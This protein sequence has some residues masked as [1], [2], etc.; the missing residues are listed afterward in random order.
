VSEHT[1]NRLHA[2]RCSGANDESSESRWG[3]LRGERRSP[4][5]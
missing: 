4:L 5:N 3:L 2:V 1:P